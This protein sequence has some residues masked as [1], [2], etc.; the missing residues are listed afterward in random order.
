TV[1]SGRS[2]NTN[3]PELCLVRGTTGLAAT[4]LH[5]GFPFRNLDTQRVFVSNIP[6]T[7]KS[8][9][10]A[11]LALLKPRV[12]MDRLVSEQAFHD[13]Q[14]TLRSAT[15]ELHPDRLHVDDDAYL[16]H[17]SWIRPAF[18]ALGDV[19]GMRVLDLR[20]GHA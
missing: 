7:E 12:A 9:D 4:R 20:C 18:A 17:E 15:F 11:L 3:P 10:A 16:D 5:Q 1:I 8:I 14:A 6:C 2:E 13:R 19:R